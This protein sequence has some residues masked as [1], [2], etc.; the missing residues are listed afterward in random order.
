VIQNCEGQCLKQ[1]NDLRSTPRRH[2][3]NTGVTEV[4]MAGLSVR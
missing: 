4:V 3:K 2:A 1:A